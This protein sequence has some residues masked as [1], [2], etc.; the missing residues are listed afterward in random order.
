MFLCTKTHQGTS[1]SCY[2]HSLL[3]TYS[4]PSISGLCK[5]VP[6]ATEC[7]ALLES[8][9]VFISTTKTHAIFMQKQSEMH[10]DKQSLQTFGH[11]DMLQ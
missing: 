8:L 11:V 6:Y 10:S 7:F 1:S 5:I 2:L 3:C 9:Y 4:E